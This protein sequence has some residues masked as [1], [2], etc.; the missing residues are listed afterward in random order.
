MIPLGVRRGRLKG[1]GVYVLALIKT[2]FKKY[3]R[4]NANIIVSSISFYILLTFIPFTLLSI[5]I[6]GLVI[7]ISNPAL[8][9]EKYLR[10]ILPDPYNAIV[11]KRVLRELNFISISKKLSGP[12]GVLFLYFFATRLFAVMRPSFRIIFGKHSTGFIK[13]K[14][15]ELF[16]TLIFALVQALIFFSFIFSLVIQTTVIKTLPGFI[17]KTVFFYAFTLAE[18][19]ITFVQFIL[20]YYF[21]TPVRNKCIIFVSTGAATLCWYLGRH[22]FKH[23]II[24]LTKVTTFFGTY[25]IFIALLFWVYFSVF[26]FILC[27]ELLSIL[28]DPVNHGLPPNS[29][30][31]SDSPSEGPIKGSHVPSLP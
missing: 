22:F 13:G 2:L 24:Y 18:I 11:V 19:A 31:S 14:G 8:H 15:E 3:Q 10:N 9:L 28:S 21:L 7:D 16:L 5:Y 4:D 27:A 12:L 1:S 26:I 17:S 25:G 29:C 20:L 30:P 6:L 23:F